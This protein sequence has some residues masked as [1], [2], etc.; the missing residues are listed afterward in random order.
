MVL[1]TV[2]S[3]VLATDIQ[4]EDTIIVTS[5]RYEEPIS[6]SLS[7]VVVVTQED[8]R[9]MQANSFSDI[10]RT[11]PDLQLYINGGRGQ[12]SKIQVRGG[13]AADTLV[14]VNGLKLNTSYDS[15]AY[16]ERIPVHQIERIEYIRG[17]RAS[18]YGSQASAAVINIITRP[19]FN[20]DNI[21]ARVQYG[22]FKNRQA[23]A[24]LKHSVG[25]NGEIKFAIGTE[26]EKGYNVHP[27][28]GLNDSDHH[29]FQHTNLMLDY[30][31][32][33]G[34][35]TL[36]GDFS[37]NKTQSQFDGS[38]TTHEY[39]MNEYN[40]YS[41]E[42]GGKYDGDIYR[43]KLNFNY[44][45]TDDYEQIVLNPYREKKS[46]NTP[47]YLRTVN[48]NWT[49]E[50]AL[51]DY[52]TLGGGVD[53]RRDHLMPNS[54]SY[55]TTIVA[56]HPLIHN[57]GAYLL[58]QFDM[59]GFQAELS[60]RY[61][62]NTQY[63]G[64]FTYQGGLGY[65]F[66]D[67][68]KVG[69]RYGTSFRA[70][71]FMELYYPYMGSANLN[72]EKSNSFEAMLRGDHKLFNWKLTFFKNHYKDRI[73]YYYEAYAFKNISKADIKGIEAEIGF[74]L[75]GIRNTISGSIKD[76]KDKTS[77]T[78]IP[79]I[80]RRDLKWT[81]LGSI[82]DFDLSAS[83]QLFSHRYAGVGSKRLGGYGILNLGV[84]Y[85]I[86]DNFKISVKADNVLD[87]RYEYARGYKTPE[88]TYSCSIDFNY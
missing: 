24:S 32:R 18:L 2:P 14:L 5:S 19:G 3:V 62:H 88:A 72:P 30:Q 13:S 79:Y 6:S 86:T 12:Q 15:S 46:D 63:G 54:K 9:K 66:L 52:V 21:H 44:Q 60:G 28:A 50:L 43:T 58:G 38:F 36:F 48:V 80:S 70:P 84:G 64:H 40:N 59:A 27:L 74:D 57:T 53:Y 25:E 16:I 47:I 69:L 34:A 51:G 78:D 61:D 67:E 4:N 41:F 8:I 20:E 33:L 37:W 75:W 77:D 56:A 81:M 85:N 83:V 68:F 7:P 11:L 87:H 45:K 71:N 35:F 17:V 49:N 73:I 82:S 65:T 55:Y 1:A 29:G 42:L 23:S 26:K 31:H 39:D 76:P 22:S 10:V